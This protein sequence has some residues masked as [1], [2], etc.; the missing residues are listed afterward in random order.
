MFVHTLYAVPA[1]GMYK[2]DICIAVSD[3][4]NCQSKGTIMPAFTNTCDYFSCGKQDSVF[5]CDVTVCKG[6][7]YIHGV[8]LLLC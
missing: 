5:F 4:Q 6:L 7:Y 3:N 2:R 8:Y 1:L